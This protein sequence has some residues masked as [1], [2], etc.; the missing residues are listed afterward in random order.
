MVFMDILRS[1]VVNKSENYYLISLNCTFVIDIM[2]MILFGSY[3]IN[4]FN[5]CL[6]PCLLFDSIYSKEFIYYSI[7]IKN[8]ITNL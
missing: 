2:I 3:S 1:K 5:I 7:D 6:I 8:E 4:M